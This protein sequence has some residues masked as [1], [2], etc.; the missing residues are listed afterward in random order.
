MQGHDLKRS[1]MASLI[2]ITTILFIV[3]DG[4]SYKR[5]G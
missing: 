1:R 3:Y 4:R 5:G 2:I